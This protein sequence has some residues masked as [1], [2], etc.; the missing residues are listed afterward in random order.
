MNFNLITEPWLPVTLADGSVARV[1]PWGIVGSDPPAVDLAAPRAEFRAALLEFLVGLLQTACPPKDDREWRKRL[2]TPPSADELRDLLTPLEPYFNLFCAAPRFLQDAALSPASPHTF[3]VRDLLIEDTTGHFA[4]EGEGEAFCP[5]CAAMALFTLQAF[6]GAGGAGIM[7]SQRGGGPLSTLV[8]GDTLWR[9]VWANVLPLTEKG[10]AAAASADLATGGVFP[11]VKPPIPAQGFT[12]KTWPEEKHSLHSYWGMPRR[13]LLLPEEV[14]APEP[15]ALC[16]EAGKVFV[17][18]YVSRPHGYDYGDTWRHPLTPYRVQ[19][20]GKPTLSVKGAANVT[21]YTHWLGVVYGDPSDSRA[22]LIPAACVRHF[23]AAK[24]DPDPAHYP[25]LGVAGF[26]MD[27]AKPRQW[28]EGRFPLL[29][30]RP[31]DEDDFRARVTAMIQAAEETRKKLM[32]A[33]KAALFPEGSPA[34]IDASLFVNAAAIFWSSTEGEFYKQAAQCAP[35]PGLEATLPARTAWAAK[36]RSAALDIF[37]AETDRG[38]FRPDEARRVVNARRI[39]LIGMAKTLPGLL[40]L[41]E[42]P[43]P[44]KRKEAAQ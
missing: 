18:R 16:A 17:R 35:D 40:N 26:D 21:G 14:A 30:V 23:R 31:E 13:I 12:D 44:K 39:L 34:K 4:P 25:G 20:G 2:D 38:R 37:D 10:V 27:K 29:H 41:P 6:A 33:L 7:T 9:T 1:A 28:C 3:P 43:K 22:P 19:G 32:G 36:L 24:D 42:A 8:R 5:A 15:C 11:W